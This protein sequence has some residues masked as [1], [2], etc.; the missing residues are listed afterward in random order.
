MKVHKLDDMKKEYETIRIPENLQ[1]NIL[2]AI[3]RA[4]LETASSQ[5]AQENTLEKPHNSHTRRKTAKPLKLSRFFTYCGSAAVAAMLIITIMANS[6][7]TV[8]HAMEQLPIIGGIVKIVTI[9]QY[10][11]TDNEM[12]ANIKI[13]EVS[14]ED[15]QGNVLEDSTKNLNDTIKAYTNELI[16]AYESDVA[17]A[18]GEGHESIAV[19][20]EVVTDNDKLFSLRFHQLIVM[21]SGNESS[22]IYHIDKTTGQMITL[23]DLFQE[24][25][26]YKTPISE[27]I[28]EQ[29]KQQMAEDENKTYWLDSEVPEWNFSEISDTVSFYVNEHG[30]LVIVF[31]EGEYAPNYMGM[32]SFEIPTE[33][34]SDIVKEG[35]LN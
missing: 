7:A 6:S 2:N 24:G 35:Y 32:T 12:N 29:M 11:H 5:P 10:E 20:Y 14:I 25:S 16:A 30:K 13:P 34:I 9:R 3:Q 22:K 33:V 15:S 27:N 1:E 17:A 19:D 31:D 26:D 28:K 21:A 4:K 8:A 23:K 18:N